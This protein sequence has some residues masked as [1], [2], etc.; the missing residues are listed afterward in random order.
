M[1]KVRRIPRSM[2]PSECGSFLFSFQHTNIM[3]D[4]NSM[5]FVSM[6]HLYIRIF[7][8]GRYQ[9]KVEQLNPLL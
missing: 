5:F 8:F 4:K 1:N 6:Y 3:F 2:Y 7:K 9:E